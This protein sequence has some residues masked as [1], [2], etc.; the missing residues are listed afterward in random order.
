MPPSAQQGQ[1][2]T[3]TDLEH[4]RARAL[5]AMLGPVPEAV[6]EIRPLSAYDALIA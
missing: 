5:K 3:I 2:I 1:R 6:V 4:A